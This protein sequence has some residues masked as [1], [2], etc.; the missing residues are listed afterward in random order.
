V[1]IVLNDF[2][3]EKQGFCDLVGTSLDNYF[4]SDY[5]K[6]AHNLSLPTYYAVLLH[7]VDE[8]TTFEVTGDVLAESVSFVA[9]M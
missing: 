3:Q 9:C 6:I 5:A 2:Q 7:A 8:D 4:T 1:H